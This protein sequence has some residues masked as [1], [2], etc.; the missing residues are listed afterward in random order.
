M[1]LYLPQL[2]QLIPDLIIL[3]LNTKWEGF[4]TK[5]KL[6]HAYLSRPEIKDKDIICFIDA[7]DVLPTKNLSALRKNYRTFKKHNP[8]VKII[9]GYDKV[10]NV[11]HEYLCRVIFGTVDAERLNSGQFIGCA[12]DIR[13]IV[14][15]ILTTTKQFQ[16]DQIELTKYANQFKEQVYIDVNQ[17]FF[18]VKSRPMQ[19]VT[20]PHSL[21]PAFIHANGNGFLDEF[22]KSEHGIKLT[23][24]EKYK[25]YI[26]N[27]LGCLRKLVLYDIIYIKRIL[28]GTPP[29]PPIGRADA[30]G[31]CIGRMHSADA[32][33]GTPPR[34]PIGRMHYGGT[35]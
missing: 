1:K 15:Y 3:G 32:L 7:Y 28:R 34:P 11:F 10:D 35:Q 23:I 13:E 12:K 29:R 30:L 33:R 6:L 18:Y 27:L 9:V 19:Q 16:T 25:N 24:K 8:Q 5:Y 4:I 14:N 31:G 2:K 26:D 20:L 22:L 21:V 17:E